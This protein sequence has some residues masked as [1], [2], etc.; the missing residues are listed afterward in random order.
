MIS[1]GHLLTKR[2]RPL[3]AETDEHLALDLRDAGIA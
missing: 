3:P 1:D 2:S